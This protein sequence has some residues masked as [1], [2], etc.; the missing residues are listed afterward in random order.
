MI[1]DVRQKNVFDT[2]HDH[3]ALLMPTSGFIEDTDFKGFKLGEVIPDKDQGKKIYSLICWE[4]GK[5][6]G[7][8]K[9]PQYI[10]S[11]LDQ[12]K[13]PAGETLAVVGSFGVPTKIFCGTIFEGCDVKKILKAMHGAVNEFVLYN[14]SLSKEEI[15]RLINS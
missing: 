11:C 2:E 14:C 1:I 10:A 5:K 15:F 12:I 3:I 9:A 13:I 4:S 7:W 6:N 8:K